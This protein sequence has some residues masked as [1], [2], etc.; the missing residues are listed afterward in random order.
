MR[1]VATVVK[2][3]ALALMVA[4]NAMSKIVVLLMLATP[5]PVQFDPN[6]V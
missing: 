1:S 3:P 6:S 5:K 4:K 2:I